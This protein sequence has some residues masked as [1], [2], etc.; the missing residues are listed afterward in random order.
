MDPVLLITI[1]ATITDLY[2]GTSDTGYVTLTM[3][4]IFFGCQNDTDQVVLYLL[5]CS[6]VTLTGYEQHDLL[7]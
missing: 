3:V 7:G 2:T 1:R 6:V 5:A 4:V